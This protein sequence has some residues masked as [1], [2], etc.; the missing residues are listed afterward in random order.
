MD[1]LPHSLELDFSPRLALMFRH[2]VSRALISLWVALLFLAVLAAS[3]PIEGP[4]AAILASNL[5]LGCSQGC[6]AAGSAQQLATNAAASL[7]PVR[8]VSAAALL[9]AVL[10]TL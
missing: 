3:S 5:N 7:T 2:V 6:P 10:A 1:K 9:G 4:L 8:F